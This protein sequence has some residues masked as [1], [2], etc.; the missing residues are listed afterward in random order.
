VNDDNLVDL[1]VANDGTANYLFLNKGGFRFEESALVSGVAGNAGGGYQ[2]G[3]GVASGDVDGDGRTDLLVTNF[4]GEGT[5][6]YRNLGQDLFTDVSGPA[7]VGLASRYLLGFGI[8]LFDVSNRGRLDVMIA[9]G[10]VNDNR[11]FYPYAMPARLYENRPTGGGFKLVDISEQ[12][13]PPWQEA[14]VGRGLAAG[15]LD[16]DGRVDAVLVAQNELLAYFH[17]QTKNPGHFVAFRLEGTKSNRDAIGARVTV[18]SGGVKQV[19][20]RLGGGSYL[21][22]CDPRIHFGLGDADR[23]ESVEVRWPSGQRDKWTDREVDRGY[24]LREGTLQS[25]PLAGFR[26]SSPG[27]TE[28]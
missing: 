26:K 8:A 28:K 14:R 7:G 1:F 24:L 4:Y 23:V 27:K 11:P 21:S 19:A 9:N 5:T 22:A 17:N 12:A 6:L 16:N 10:H 25:L 2:A 15:D 13:G 20:H 18:T 3:M